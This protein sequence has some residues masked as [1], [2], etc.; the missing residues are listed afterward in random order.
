MGK[1]LSTIFILMAVVQNT[2]IGK[3]SGSVGGS[4]FSSWKGKNILKAKATEVANP[5][6]PKQMARRA[7]F[8][9]LVAWY[10]LLSSVIIVGFTELAVGMS[11]FNAFTSENIK[12]AYNWSDK[13]NPVFIPASFKISKGSI[14]ATAIATAVIDD[15]D[16]NAVV[17]W[18]KTP[19]LPG[20]A[21]I[22]PAIIAIY[23]L[24]LTDWLFP[25]TAAT[26]TAETLTVTIPATW[27]STNECYVYLGFT[28]I[29]GTKAADSAY[30][31]AVIQV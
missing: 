29:E 27:V 10:R 2:L 13:E 19:L 8:T 20:Q 14:S 28:N 16:N 12:N 23:N 3:A 30:K 15:S 5:Q 18:V 4:T 22:D 26:R 24:T 25:I 9:T 17:T 1:T 11:T 31:N 7:V 21:L 6:K